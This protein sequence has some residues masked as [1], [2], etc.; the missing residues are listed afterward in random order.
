MHPAETIVVDTDT[1]ACD[2]G[3]GSLGH[4]VVYLPLVREGRAEC[5]YCGRTYILSGH[6]E[7]H[8]AH[9]S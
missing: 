4:P 7:G 2:G 8:A 6:G 1:V 3:G 9:A 5:P